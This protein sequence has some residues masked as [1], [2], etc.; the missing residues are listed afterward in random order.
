M[1]EF[2]RKKRKIVLDTSVFINPDVR[3]AFGNNPEEAI[4]EFIKIIKKIEIFEF[5]LPSSVFKELMYFVDEKKISK[6]FYFFIR[7]KSPDKHRTT[8]PAIFFYELVE[9]MR[10]RI[11]KGLRVAEDAVRSGTQK[12]M[13][14]TIK[15]LRK[16]YREALREGI[17]DSKEDV[18]L[19][20]LSLEL[21]ATLVTGDQ[22]L[23]K[24]ADK[25]GIEWIVP[26][27]FKDFLL[28]ACG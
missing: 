19:I 9:E 11:N 12:G 23:I 2:F 28:S 3:G 6:E 22:G 13:D 17:I 14:E 8:C 20:F 15:D 18:D 21:K 10:I 5:Y 24:W 16:K 26:E 1:I 4:E 27:K 7:I 25:L